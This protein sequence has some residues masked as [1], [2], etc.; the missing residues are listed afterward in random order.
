[1]NGIRA[2][3]L[4]DYLS[5]RITLDELVDWAEKAMR[6]KVYKRMTFPSCEKY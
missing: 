5:L 2:P 3:K 6:E 1:M 4:I